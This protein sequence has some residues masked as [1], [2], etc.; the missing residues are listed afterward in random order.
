MYRSLIGVVLVML[1]CTGCEPLADV[2]ANVD[3]DAKISTGL[4][5]DFNFRDMLRFK[6]DKEN[7]IESNRTDIAGLKANF[8]M[9]T[10]LTSK[11]QNKLVEVK[12]DFKQEIETFKG[13]QNI[14]AFS[15]G[16][17][18]VTL[19]AFGMMILW[20][21][22]AYFFMISKAKYRRAVDCMGRGIA[23][24][25]DSRPDTKASVKSGELKDILKRHAQAANSKA[26]IDDRLTLMQVKR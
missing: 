8:V 23:E 17:L 4:N 1:A 5:N 10:E 21:C 2:K 15:G 25:L 7:V 20:G 3:L 26:L 6:A 12:K 11:I 13:E 16:G 24:Y 9:T 22:A 14:G 19:V 18:Y